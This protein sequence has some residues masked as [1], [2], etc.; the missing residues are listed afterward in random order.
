MGE[1][2]ARYRRTRNTS[3]RDVT[4]RRVQ[5]VPAVL[6]MTSVTS[7]PVSP[8]LR[9]A[10]P[11][12]SARLIPRPNRDPRQGSPTRHRQQVDW[13]ESPQDRP[14]AKST[15]ASSSDAGFDEQPDAGQPI[16]RLPWTPRP[17]SVLEWAPLARHT[18]EPPGDGGRNGHRRARQDRIARIVAIGG[19]EGPR[20]PPTRWEES[21]GEFGAALAAAGG[22]DGPTS[23]R[24]HAQAE[25]VLLGPTPVV[26]LVGALGHFYLRSDS[27][28]GMLARA[29]DGKG[30]AMARSPYGTPVVT[31]K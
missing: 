13:R 11:E 31:V 27:V 12:T 9:L 6:V 19:D 2:T 8:R 16:H 28:P 4:R 25:A 17:R 21:G 10:V 24:A 3:G 7:S 1:I 22:Q 14:R 5:V 30:A 26:R 29:P 23:A 18:D 20:D 15:D